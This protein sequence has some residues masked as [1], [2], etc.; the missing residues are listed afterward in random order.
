M[1]PL[2]A[3][4]VIAG[5]NRDGSSFLGVSDMY[6]TAYEDDIITTGMAT[7]MKGKQLDEAVMK[8]RED[9]LKAIEEVVVGIKSRFILS[10]GKWDVLDVTPE[11]IEFLDQMDPETQWNGFLLDHAEDNDGWTAVESIP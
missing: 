11:G 6:G 1:N 4:F 8:N 3:K 2:L 7:H 9:V 10:M 5:I